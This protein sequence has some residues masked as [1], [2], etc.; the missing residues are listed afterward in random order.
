MNAFSTAALSL[1]FCLGTA[2]LPAGGSPMTRASLSSSGAEGNGFSYQPSVAANGRYVAFVSDAANLVPGDTNGVGDVFVRDL[3]LGAPTRVSVGPGGV[4]ANGYSRGPALSADGRFVVFESTATNLDPADATGILDIFLHDRTTGTTTLLSKNVIGVPGNDVSAAARISGDGRFVV[5]HSRAANL[6]ANDTNGSDDVFLVDRAL[7]KIE[8]V[9]VSSGGLQADSHCWNPDVDD[10]GRFVV[11]DSAAGNLV[12]G[13]TNAASDVFLRDRLAGT[14]TRISL[15]RLGRQVSGTSEAARLAGTGLA[16]SFT[17]SASTLVP[18]DANNAPDVFVWHG[19]G[20]LEC[21]SLTT[22]RVPGNG[23]NWNAAISKA[24]DCVVFESSSTDLVADDLNQRLDVFV[25][26]LVQGRTLLVSC[27]H[28][29]AF[30]NSDSRFAAITGDGRHV[31]FS[32]DSGN[33]VPGDVNRTTDVFVRDTRPV[34][35]ASATTFGLGCNGTAGVPALIRSADTLPWFGEVYTL[36]ARNIPFQASAVL[37][38]GLSRSSWSGLALPF[39]LT[40]IG[41]PSCALAVSS[42]V[43]IPIGA[44]WSIVI[45]DSAAV[46]GA[47]FFNQLVVRDP[48]AN[49]LGFTVSNAIESTVGGA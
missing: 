36:E 18:G 32:S 2:P 16:I 38:F 11:F 26:D 3:V 45:P 17:S 28:G 39:D 31:V 40:P 42:E 21:A 1:L 47:K 24:G 33:L 6:V 37:L 7:G 27:N 34:N 44:T 29:G 10:S 49:V 19:E 20:N 13:D 8:R 25:R 22:A 46:I 35:S 4:Q 14:T 5:F 15:D 41:M 12:A 43:V 48:W 30:G 9:S 23:G